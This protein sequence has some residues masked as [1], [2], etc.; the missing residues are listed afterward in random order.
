MFSKYLLNT[1]YMPVTIPGVRG[2]AMNKVD[3]TTAL[4]ELTC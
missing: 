1:Y 3:K 2:T 4:V